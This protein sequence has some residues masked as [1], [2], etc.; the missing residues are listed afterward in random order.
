MRGKGK[1]SNQGS[2]VGP[3]L[4]TED[5]IFP[6]VHAESAEKGGPIISPLSTLSDN[7]IC[8]YAT[9]LHIAR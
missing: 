7:R 2:L 4:P 1:A 8:F 3:S 9:A 5:T 6:A